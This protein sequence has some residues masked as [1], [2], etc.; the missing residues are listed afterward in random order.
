MDTH[1]PAAA[2]VIGNDDAVN[3]MLDVAITDMTFLRTATITVLA[4]L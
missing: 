3:D 4:T 1:L 2:V